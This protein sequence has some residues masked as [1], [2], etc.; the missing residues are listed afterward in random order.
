MDRHNVRRRLCVAVAAVAVPAAALAAV[1]AVSSIDSPG[2]AQAQRSDPCRGL[3]KGRTVPIAAAKLIVEYNATDDDLGVH[4]AF[5]SSGWR[6]LCVYDPR[7][8]P[9][10]EV[11]PRSQLADLTMGAI[12]FESRE[13][14]V[15][16]FGF[17]E[18]KARFPEGRYRVR[19]ATFDGKRLVGHATFSHDV[20]KEPRITAPRDGAR[21]DPASLRVTWDDVTE[22]VDGDP[23]RITGY[24][25]IVTKE[26][27]DDPHGFSRP[28]YD[29]H[30]P[31][32][33]NSLSVPAEFLERRGEYELEV[34]ALERSGNQ[35]I[36]VRFFRTI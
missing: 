15:D 33:R 1:A 34:L 6:K 9:V 2:A 28:V 14:P 11:G 36:S 25:V 35:T 12:F 32:D 24:E 20:P 17:E 13:P 23:V 5:D 10:L 4:G 3:G 21:V 30:L 29:V 26:Q 22:T 31:P 19:G 16:R 8:R 27:K 7:G 18:L